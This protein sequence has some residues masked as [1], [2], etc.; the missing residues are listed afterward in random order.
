ME[1]ENNEYE[2]DESENED[3]DTQ[4]IVIKVDDTPKISLKTIANIIQPQTLKLKGN[5]KNENVTVLIDTESTHN[6]LDIR[7]ARKLKLFMHQVPYMK[8][9]V[10]DGNTIEKVG[11]CQKV[12]VQIQEFKLES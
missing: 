3:E 7:V 2:E 1:E 5:I 11:K 8:V 4:N 10:L 6:F 12:K 9:M